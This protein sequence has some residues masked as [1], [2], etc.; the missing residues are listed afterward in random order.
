MFLR[1][2]LFSGGDE[3]SRSWG[4]R[5]EL[6]RVEGGESDQ[7]IVYERRI[8]KDLKGKRHVPFLP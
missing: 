4:G 6:G 3:G 7:D 2:L 8:H 1:G 5:V